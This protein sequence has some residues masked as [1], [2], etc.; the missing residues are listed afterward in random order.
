[1][2]E[3]IDYKVVLADLK[4]RRAALDQAIAAIEVIAGNSAFSGVPTQANGMNQTTEILPDT[5]IG[6]NIAEAGAAYLK[7]V[8]RPARTT[9]AIT[10]ALNLGGLNVSQPSV[11]TILLRSDRK[12]DGEVIRVG[13]GLWGLAD[14][15]PKRPRVRRVKDTSGVEGDAEQQE[16]IGEMIEHDKERRGP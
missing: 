14:W 7:M 8:G 10:G 6:H 9:E 13:R 16:Q 1:M 11:A 12:G 15:Y 3:G 2:P 4:A 5:F